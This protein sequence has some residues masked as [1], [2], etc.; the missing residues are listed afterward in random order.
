[1]MKTRD[2]LLLGTLAGAGLA[3]GARE[4]LRA[5]RRITLD[6]RVVVITGGSTGHGLVAARLAAE[7]GARLVIAARD[8]EELRAAEAGLGRG[9]ARD[10]LAVLADVTDP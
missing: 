10:V 2:K 5:Q 6:D 3:W 7:G 4:V 1:M 8:A 9:W